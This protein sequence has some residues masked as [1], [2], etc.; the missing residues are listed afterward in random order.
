VRLHPGYV[1]RTPNIKSSVIL[2]LH[3]PIIAKWVATVI[4][5]P[6]GFEA[7]SLDMAIQATDICAVVMD[8]GSAI[9]EW[10]VI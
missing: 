7:H 3:Y 4:G 9:I 1:A 5:R 2:L 6:Q 8:S 10:R